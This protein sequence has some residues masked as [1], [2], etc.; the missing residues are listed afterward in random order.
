MNR[1]ILLV[2]VVGYIFLL[3]HRALMPF[4]FDYGIADLP[5][6]LKL[7]RWLPILS[8]EGYF[9]LVGFLQQI[10][11][12][13]PLGGLAYAYFFLSRHP[14]P[15][16][17]AMAIGLGVS[18]FIESMQI[19][20]A[21][22]YAALY[23]FA[24]NLLGTAIGAIF[25]Y[26]M[27]LNRSLNMRRTFYGYVTKRPFLV[28]LAA[29]IGALAL[30]AA[31]PFT[32][33]FGFGDIARNIG[34]ANFSLFDF[35]S[36]ATYYIDSHNSFANTR[37]DPT[38]FIRD[39]IYAALMGY[40][41][42]ICY[43]LYWRK[44]PDGIM[45]LI[46]LPL[47]I[48]AG[49][50][51]F[52]IFIFDR[53]S[54]I[55]DVAAGYLGIGAGFLLYEALRTKRRH[56]YRSDFDLLAIPLVMYVVYVAWTGMRPFDWQYSG[57]YVM[58]QLTAAS[59]APFYAYL[60]KLDGAYLS[61][62]F[63]CLIYFTPIAMYTAYK[64]RLD[65]KEWASIYSRTTIQAL[66]FGGIIEVTQLLSVQQYANITDVLFFTLGGPFGTFIIYYWESILLPKIRK[67][68]RGL[69]EFQG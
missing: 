53:I 54:D 60:I 7:I 48:F 21:S 49:V 15:L 1:K 27:N 64:M 39:I 25:A 42:R 24:N 23:D 30:E 18:I 40:I 50:E 2:L 68:E 55:N 35:N 16:P 63:K 9:P 8:A 38:I 45:M 20:S 28:L 29:M 32:F 61:N 5:A 22:Q 57:Q 51:A 56:S 69:L 65:E 67:G 3:L 12:F 14:S 47:V 34:M 33:T 6:Q 4:W 17:M 52:Q 26:I 11:L 31:V 59:L 41:F 37:F 44:K 13:I 66:M 36:E 62:L 10:I 43:R 46:G 58:N 19:F